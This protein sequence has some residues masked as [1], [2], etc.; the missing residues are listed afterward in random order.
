LDL[1]PHPTGQSLGNGVAVYKAYLPQRTEEDYFL[2]RVDHHMSGGDSMFVRYT[3]DDGRA[4]VPFQSTLVPGFDGRREN[5]NQNLMVNWQNVRSSNFINEVKF[6]FSRVRLDATTDNLHPLSIS[7]VPNRPMG[8][9]NI[10][11]L[12]LLGNNIVFPVGS[13]SNTFELIDNAA[14]QLGRNQLKYG[15][16]F[17]RLQLNSRYDVAVDGQYRFADLSGLGIPS[18]SNNAPLEF[19]LKGIPLFYLGVDPQAADSNR[20]YRQNYFGLYMQDNW[21]VGPRL[22]INAGL[23][24]EYWSNPSEVH[25]RSANI[26]S[27]KTDTAPTVGKIW[28]S[29]PANLFSP[30]VGLVWS[31]GS[32]PSLVIRAG[33]GIFRDQ[34]WGNL[35]SNTRFYSPF[36]LPVLSLFP[37]FLA[38]PNTAGLGGIK[39]PTPGSFGVTYQADFPYYA[40][41]SLSVQKHLPSDIMLEVAYSGS[42]GIHLPRA[43]EANLTPQGPVNP[44]FG[45]LPMIATD[46]NSVYNSLQLSITKRMARNFSIQ[47]AYTLSKSVDDQSG[48]FPSDWVSESG[49]SQDYYNR[50]GDRARSSFDRRHVFVTNFVYGLPGLKSTN[51]FSEFLSDWQ[52]TGIW[53]LMSG[54]PFTANLGSFNNS[55][56]NSSNPADRPDLRD[57]ADPCKSIIGTPEKWFDPTI[58]KLPAPGQYGNSGRNTLCGP[59][60]ASLDLGLAK[61]FLTDHKVHVQFRAEFLNALNRTNLSVPVNTQGAAGFGG[62]GDAVFVGRQTSGC[63][64]QTD[65]YGCGIIAPDAGRIF[66]T[67]GDSRQIQFALKL[68]F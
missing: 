42:R 44:N 66:S 21:S 51:P 54:L 27:L 37:N 23:R 48:V 41:Y 38:P 13:A 28:E 58:F 7:L 16:D 67:A 60:F 55:L 57:G 39:T 5:R 30:R 4:Q 61:T 8:G 35:Y 19:F 22:T 56:T 46:A 25:D 33:S 32:G 50:T 65:P 3:F 53:R 20:G 11:G 34:L 9:I 1:Y 68:L 64:P 47:A 12:P 43:G 15:V 36:Y 26:R 63:Q 24:W 10:S 14:H 59:D 52:V 40:K 29:V 31:I 49:V 45:S 62:N 2:L 17:K 6:Q 18:S